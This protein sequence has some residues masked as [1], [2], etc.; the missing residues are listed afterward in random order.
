MLKVCFSLGFWHQ[1]FVSPKFNLAIIP[2][3]VRYQSLSERTF[4]VNKIY[5]WKMMIG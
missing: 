2:L 1:N 4:F 3:A 5:A